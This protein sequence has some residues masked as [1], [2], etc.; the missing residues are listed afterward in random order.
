MQEDVYDAFMDGFT[1]AVKALKVG[2][3][4]SRLPRLDNV[5]TTEE[6]ITILE[7]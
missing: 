6:T 7:S 5:I 3:E 4:R 1:A 2:A